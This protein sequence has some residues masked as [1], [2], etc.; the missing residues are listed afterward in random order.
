MSPPDPILAAAADVAFNQAFKRYLRE[1][2]REFPH[3][4]ELRHALVVYKL[5][6]TV[7][8]A[9]P[10]LGFLRY[11]HAPFHRDIRARRAFFM[12]MTEREFG[13]DAQVLAALHA[14]MKAMWAEMTPERQQDH[15][16][17]LNKLLD[18]GSP[19]E[20]PGRARLDD[21]AVAPRAERAC[22]GQ[23]WDS[24]CGHASAIGHLNGGASGE[25]VIGP[26]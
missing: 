8:K 23:A 22:G 10:R 13:A 18:L 17:R 5:S 14:P 12:D 3:V 2:I 26:G 1:L 11:I 24:G 6:K 9:L 19:V 25:R 7:C 21:S 4:V 15:W 16:D 20:E